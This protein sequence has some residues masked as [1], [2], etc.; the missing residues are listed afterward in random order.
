MPPL[1]DA[2]TRAEIC[3]AFEERAVDWKRVAAEW[4]LK[5]LGITTRAVEDAPYQHLVNGGEVSQVKETRPEYT[6]REYHYDFRIIIGSR[7]IYVETVLDK[8]RMGLYVYVV[9]I[10]DA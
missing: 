3:L 9:S 4:V 8:R 5:E 2:A 1:R 10:H 6:F 7:S